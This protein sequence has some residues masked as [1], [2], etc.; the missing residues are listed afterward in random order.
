MKSI[1]KKKNK[2]QYS[3]LKTKAQIADY[4]LETWD[5]HPDK[6]GQWM[7]FQD[8][9]ENE[10]PHWKNTAIFIHLLPNGN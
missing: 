2:M 1:Y 7:Q 10:N 5:K 6:F 4:F 8:C 3:F 9:K